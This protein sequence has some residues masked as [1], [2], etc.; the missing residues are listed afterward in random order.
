MHVC[1]RLYDKARER[2]KLVIMRIEFIDSEPDH[3][4]RFLASR[5][6]LLQRASLSQRVARKSNRMHPCT[7]DA[8]A[9]ENREPHP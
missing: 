2:A 6:L 3:R 1:R 7:F 9:K 4:N 5:D 8:N